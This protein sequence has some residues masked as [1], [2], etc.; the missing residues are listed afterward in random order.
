MTTS[1]DEP[2]AD[3]R[4]LELCARGLGKTFDDHCVLKNVDLDIRRG[5]IL[6]IVGTSGC[7]KTVLLHMLLGLLPPT[8]GAI[9]VADHEL[10]GAPLID[11]VHAKQD[12]VYEVRLSWAVVFQHNA[13]F[14]DTVYE[15]CALWLR[16]H[17]KLKESAIREQVR[18][19][20]EAVKLDVDDV[21]DKQR[22]ELSGGMAKRVAVARALAADPLV[23]F[24]DEPTTG[25]D[26]VNAAH[27]HDLI[28]NTHH[29]Q[30]ADGSTRTTV[31]VTHDK[32]L[33]R[34]LHPRVLLL[35]DAGVCFD[36]TYDEF[37]A[38]PLEPVRAYLAEMPGLHARPQ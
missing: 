33:L 21:I 25:L 5:E 12:S 14:G 35:H 19:C 17:T 31:V 16:E 9:E 6:A 29:S 13:L 37:L 26:P 38:S 22:D 15:N 3:P 8:A 2:A 23:V 24:Y 28:W 18:A 20:L 1:I 30:R 34:R 11:L 7:G 27:V 32:D 36:G 10:P 4:L